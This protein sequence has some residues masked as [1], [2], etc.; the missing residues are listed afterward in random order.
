MC[1]VNTQ[2]L[3]P[4]RVEQPYLLPHRWYIDIGGYFVA[5]KF[6]LGVAGYLAWPEIRAARKITT[7]HHLWLS[8]PFHPL[9]LCGEGART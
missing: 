6:P 1:T 2:K 8:P 9:F 3:A 5:G 4:L 7:M